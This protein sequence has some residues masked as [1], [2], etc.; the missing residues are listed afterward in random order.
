[1]PAAK[2]TEEAK[3]ALAD[4][5]EISSQ[6]RTAVILDAGGAVVACTADDDGR[7]SALAEAASKLLAAA[8]KTRHGLG[9][10][11]LTQLEAATLEGSV[12]VVCEG[13]STIAATTTPEPTVGLVFYDLKSTLRRARGDKPK[14]PA[15]KAREPKTK[16]EKDEKDEKPKATRTRKKPEA[17]AAA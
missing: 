16:D 6:V 9:P 3:Q 5:T 11:A 8:A 1:M 15:A 10:G 7:A 17:D 13:G 2:A 14:A 12:F 4:L